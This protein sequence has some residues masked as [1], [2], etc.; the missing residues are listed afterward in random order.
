MSSLGTLYK[1]D[2]DVC[3]M[4][5]GV[6]LTEVFYWYSDLISH[7]QTHTTHSGASRLTHSY[8]YIFTPTV[9]YRSNY[10]Y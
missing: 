4:Q 5:Q 1:K 7:T 8:K 9:M 10:L 6:S 2:L 3:F